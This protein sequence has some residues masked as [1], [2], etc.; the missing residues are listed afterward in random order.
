ME[1]LKLCNFIVRKINVKRLDFIQVFFINYMV[2]KYN[3]DIQIYTMENCLTPRTMSN[4]GTAPV[5]C[6]MLCE[7]NTGISTGPKAL[8]FITISSFSELFI[9]IFNYYI[10]FNYKPTERNLLSPCA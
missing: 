3:L 10:I 9:I 7:C 4:R 2:A 5:Y 8:A 1:M 6:I